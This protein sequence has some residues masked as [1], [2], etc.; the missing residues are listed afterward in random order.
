METLYPRLA[1]RILD[2]LP[3]LRG[4][5]LMPGGERAGDGPPSLI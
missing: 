4:T 2:F 5:R 3:R 1:G